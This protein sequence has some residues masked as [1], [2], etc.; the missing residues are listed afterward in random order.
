MTEAPLHRTFYRIFPFI[1]FGLLIPLLFTGCGGGQLNN[2]G[3]VTA[4]PTS[5]ITASPASI[6][7]GSSST[8]TV[9]ATNASKV[10]GQAN[11]A[12]GDTISGF[13][14]GD[15]A[16]VVSGSASLTTTA[17]TSSG[18]GAYAITAAQG[19]LNAANYTFAFSNGTLTVNQAALNITADNAS[20]TYGQSLAFAGTEFTTSGLVN[21]DT[22]S[23]VT[24]TSGGSAATATVSGSPYAIAASA[25]SGT[26]L[27]NYSIT[28]VNG[29]LNVTPASLTVTVTNAT[30]VYGQ[31]NPAFSD[32]LTGFV[33]AENASV[34]S[35]S[36]SL[37]TTATAGSSVGSYT[38][39][40]AQGGLSAPNYTFAFANG[41]LTI[42]P[43]VAPTPP[44]SLVPT[45]P[46]SI[47]PL[48]LVPV[49]TPVGPS[50]VGSTGTSPSA[51]PNSGPPSAL[52]SPALFLTSTAPNS[53]GTDVAADS[54]LILQSSVNA[55][56]RTIHVFSP[57]PQVAWREG[58]TASSLVATETPLDMLASRVTAASTSASQA[59][60]AQ[61]DDGLDILNDEG[62]R[63][64]WTEPGLETTMV[65][66]TGV[67]AASGYVLLNSRLGLW[68]LGLL[69]SQPLWKQFDPLEV[70]Y[71]WEEEEDRVKDDQ[72]EETLL[73]LVD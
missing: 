33:N 35:G 31:A 10:Y 47:P 29:T 32:T 44:P 25:A 61:A 2:G 53:R 36:A 8:L 73:S 28:Y 70:L 27:G 69:T 40:A 59:R 16:S 21:S 4:V 54:S 72:E 39:T 13:V 5:L 49:T 46:A 62:E 26:G 3:S 68:L 12:F 58:Q 9:T 11:P 6:L 18:V 14:N 51:T 56:T 55:A 20:K 42:T 41:T 1:F 60:A 19:S 64:P 52:L 24:L 17:T 22:V 34:V 57:V 71:A 43:V 67:V 37:T 50:G 63:V 38:I 30:K 45:P 15:T 66:G 65:I 48:S 23:G 7:L